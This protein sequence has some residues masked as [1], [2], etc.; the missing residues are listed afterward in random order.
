MN[1][2]I[3]LLAI[4]IFVI[5]MLS[6]TRMQKESKDEIVE[7]SPSFT[8]KVHQFDEL[9]PFSEGMAAVKKDDKFGFINT[10]GELVIPCQY[11]YAGQFKGGLACV[12]KDE[13]NNNISFIDATG[14]MLHTKFPFNS[15]Y[16]LGTMGQTY[17]GP[18]ISFTNGVCEIKYTLGDNIG[19]EPQTVYID[20]QMKEVAQPCEEPTQPEE[21]LGYEIFSVSDKDI[22]GEETN[23]VGVKD[24]DG[25]IV[26]PAKY[27]DLVICDNGVVLA[28]MFIENA[29]SRF[30]HDKI[31]YGLTVYGY[32]DFTG[33]STFTD[34]DMGKLE[35]YKEAQ[36]PAMAQLKLEAEQE[37]RQA[38]Y[39]AE[40]TRRQ[41]GE[42]V[43]SALPMVI[44]LLADGVNLHK[45]MFRMAKF[46]FLRIQKFMVAIG[47]VLSE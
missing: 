35:G 13:G 23:L 24:K 11:Q 9:Y 14:K 36:I 15:Y 12:V 32:I 44:T 16:Y 17:I 39:E 1:K 38:Q 3:K 21:N 28:R 25:K 8:E 4:S 27:H 34:A 10:K 45:D 22:Y 20:R 2:L 40:Q 47:N 31:G 46:G 43:K 42:I 5:A 26:I 6:C 18:A 30:H 19:E 29:E 33:K 37:E 41:Q 7:I